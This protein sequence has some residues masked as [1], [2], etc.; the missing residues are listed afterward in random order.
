[1]AA[2]VLV[3][4]GPVSAATAVGGWT[5]AVTVSGGFRNAGGEGVQLAVGPNNVIA[6]TWDHYENSH[7]MVQVS[8]SKDKGLTWS[9][10][11]TISATNQHTET[12]HVAINGSGAIM[13]AWGN[14]PDGLPW[15]TEYSVSTDAGASWSHYA[16]VSDDSFSSEINSLV[17][18]GDH[19]FSILMS[20]PDGPLGDVVHRSTNDDGTSWSTFNTVSNSADSAF[21][22]DQAVDGV[23]NIGAVF[24]K[25]VGSQWEVQARTSRDGGVTWSAITDVYA[26]HEATNYPRILGLPR[27]G[28]TVVWE[29]V[30][31]VTHEILASTGDVRPE[32]TSWT[33]PVPAGFTSVG[34]APQFGAA[35]GPNGEVA[36]VWTM[37][38]SGVRTLFCVLSHDG[39][40]T[41]DLP[42][43][44]AEAPIASD[45]PFYIP[46][47]TILSTGEVAVGWTHVVDGQGFSDVVSVA[48][49]S[50]GARWS[51]P[52]DVSGPGGS[53][54][55]LAPTSTGDVV[56]AWRLAIDDQAVTSV[57]Q[58]ST[59]LS[60]TLPDT[61]VAPWLGVAVT[62]ATALT[63]LGVVALV[64]GRRRS[65]D[66]QVRRT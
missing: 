12:P 43:A 14:E 50:D 6:A 58:A 10:P 34:G 4:T 30:P 42:S 46:R 40:L 5:P 19:G 63:G 16:T 1:M 33:A 26:G 15:L 51:D 44:V 66:A 18:L 2:V 17:A 11:Q 38:D 48:M 60:P 21:F 64:V 54:V 45:F 3:V 9:P 65:A 53:G 28:F 22:F 61:G 36:V 7:Y 20:Q 41:W 57:V 62:G 31:G 27:G 13:V 24:M 55:A 32:G 8:V 37:D 25:H 23:G 59:H 49:S 35:A 56:A 52:V 29:N 47:V 39:G